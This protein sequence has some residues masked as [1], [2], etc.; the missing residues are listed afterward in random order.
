[1][2]SRASSLVSFILYSPIL[3]L[4]VSASATNNDKEFRLVGRKVKYK[5]FQLKLTK[6]DFRSDQFYQSLTTTS[7]LD[8]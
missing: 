4:V 3:P 5:Y 1:M 6:D 8:N 2:L 7:W